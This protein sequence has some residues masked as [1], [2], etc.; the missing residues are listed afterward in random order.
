MSTKEKTRIPRTTP[1][2]VISLVFHA[3]SLVA[4]IAA[5]NSLK[6]PSPI[7]NFIQNQYGTWYQFL[8]VLGLCCAMGS[9]AVATLKDL[10]PQVKAFDVVKNSLGIVSV[11]LEGLISVLY[12]GLRAYDPKLLVPPDPRYQIPLVMDLSLHALPALLL[13]IDFL[14]LSPPFSAASS[15]ILLSSLLT[16]GYACWMEHCAR[17]N[18][19]FPYPFLGDMQPLARAAFY[20]ACAIVNVVLFE[21]ANAIHLLFDRQRGHD[22]HRAKK[23]AEGKAE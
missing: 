16:T 9:M 2:T 1:S 12:W 5:F 22:V 20:S 15:P 23:Q 7:A 17:I 21:I 8:T 6:T 13:W 18:G 19:N 4:L 14:F 11:P 10:L 3:S